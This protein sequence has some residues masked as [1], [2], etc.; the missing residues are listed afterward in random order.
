MCIL[1][2]VFVFKNLQ[3]AI[4][5]EIGALLRPS[6]VVREFYRVECNAI[7]ARSKPT[8]SPVFYEVDVVAV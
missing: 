5:E 1:L 3:L 7:G 8:V 2:R 6:L 4:L